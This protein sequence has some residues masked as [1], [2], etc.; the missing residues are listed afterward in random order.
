MATCSRILPLNRLSRH[1]VGFLRDVQKQ[2]LQAVSAFSTSSVHDKEM[3]YKLVVLGGG[4]GGAAAAH[5]F[6]RKLGSGQVAVVEPSDVS[7]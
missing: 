7:I 6:G 2:Y 4:A 1:S 3:S 5:M